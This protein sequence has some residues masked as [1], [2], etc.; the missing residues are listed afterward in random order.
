[1]SIVYSVQQ[2]L[3]ASNA[4]CWFPSNCLNCWR[5]DLLHMQS[6]GSSPVPFSFTYTFHDSKCI[7]CEN[8]FCSS[9]IHRLIVSLVYTG[10]T[11]G[12][13]WICPC[14]SLVIWKRWNFISSSTHYE[15]M[16]QK[17]FI[18]TKYCSLFLLIEDSF[19]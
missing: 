5:N 4:I 10:S 1:M 17:G 15:T 6:P 14:Y 19:V 18:I 2:G 16:I 11:W 8:L 9:N 12:Y 3:I 7:H 13:F